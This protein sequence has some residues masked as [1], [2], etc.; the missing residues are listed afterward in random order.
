MKAF[1]EFELGWVR[2]VVFARPDH[3]IAKGGLASGWTDLSSLRE[4]AAISR[5]ADGSSDYRK[6]E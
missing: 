1:G 2:P 5:K 4:R 3:Q 6:T